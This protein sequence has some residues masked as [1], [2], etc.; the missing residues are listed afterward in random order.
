M[1]VCLKFYQDVFV[2]EAW[3]IATDFLILEN[4][5]LIEFGKWWTKLPKLFRN[6]NYYVVVLLFKFGHRVCGEA[7]VMALG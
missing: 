1:I 2:P 4:S 6:M 3:I 5:D 7:W